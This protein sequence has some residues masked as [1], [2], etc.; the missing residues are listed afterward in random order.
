MAG[1]DNGAG[2]PDSHIYTVSNN[3]DNSAD[4]VPVSSRNPYQREFHFDP[5]ITS[6]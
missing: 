1:K 3:R 5:P 6:S 2:K 4:S